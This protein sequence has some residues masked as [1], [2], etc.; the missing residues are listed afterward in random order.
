[1]LVIAIR[2]RVHE[3]GWED[4]EQSTKFKGRFDLHCQTAIHLN[5][6]ARDVSGIVR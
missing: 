1:M 2:L 3:T 4:K 5:Y 6:L